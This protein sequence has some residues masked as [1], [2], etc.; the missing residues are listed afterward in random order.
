MFDGRSQEAGWKYYPAPP[1]IERFVAAGVPF[2]NCVG[3]ARRSEH[4][5][6]ESSVLRT[7]PADSGVDSLQAYRGAD[8][9][10]GPARCTATDEGVVVS[11]PG[12]ITLTV[13]EITPES[14]DHV[15]G[16]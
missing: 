7:F 16:S 10:P 3:T 8:P 9:A 13:G 2:T 1:L 5:A 4:V 11:G 14:R 12:D 15:S 6:Y